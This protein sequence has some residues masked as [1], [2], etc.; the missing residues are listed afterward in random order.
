MFNMHSK[1]FGNMDSSLI[2]T[3][4]DANDGLFVLNTKKNNDVLQKQSYQVFILII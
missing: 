2:G 4:G 3:K 1:I